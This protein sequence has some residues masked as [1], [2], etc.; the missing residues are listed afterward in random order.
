ML[1]GIRKGLLEDMGVRMNMG[2][3]LKLA[4]LVW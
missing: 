1:A 3:E 4:R 2:V